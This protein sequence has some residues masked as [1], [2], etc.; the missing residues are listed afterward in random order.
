M[1]TTA[2]TT[3]MR[4]CLGGVCVHVCMFVCVCVCVLRFSWDR[5]AA[6]G[7]VSQAGIVR[8]LYPCKTDAK[9]I[10]TY[11]VHTCTYTKASIDKLISPCP[12][13]ACPFACLPVSLSICLSVCMKV[14]I[15]ATTG[16]RKAKFAIKIRRKLR[17]FQVWDNTT[18]AP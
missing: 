8:L 2:A 5:Q 17:V 4:L 7:A 18:N 10:L 16:A 6:S 1:R 14:A 12:L 9:G 15:S 3:L 11:V 13:S